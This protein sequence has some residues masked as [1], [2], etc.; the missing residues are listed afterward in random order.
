MRENYRR[1][2]NATVNELGRNKNIKKYHTKMA[3]FEYSRV[4]SVFLVK[5]KIGINSEKCIEYGK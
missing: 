2:Y 5:K 3:D 4:L 1:V